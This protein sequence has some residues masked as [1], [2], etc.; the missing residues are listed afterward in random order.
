MTD[1]ADLRR[2]VYDAAR[3]PARIDRLFVCCRDRKQYAA[4]CRELGVPE[5]GEH[6]LWV[7]DPS[8][9]A[10]HSGMD[11]HAL[12]ASPDWQELAAACYAQGGRWALG[13]EI[14]L[15]SERVRGVEHR[16]DD[17]LTQTIRR[18]LADHEDARKALQRAQARFDEIGNQLA[19][20]RA[21]DPAAYAAARREAGA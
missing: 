3:Q 15:W 19:G 11:Y 12:M 6:I 13:S 1:T 17:P 16:Q 7:N 5:T 4:W 20:L 10:G 14:N 21:A 9:L 18:L 2:R 8:V